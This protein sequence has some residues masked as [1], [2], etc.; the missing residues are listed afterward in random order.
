VVIK[1]QMDRLEKLTA[2]LGELEVHV[3]QLGAV[4]DVSVF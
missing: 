1:F 4:K 3:N 2:R